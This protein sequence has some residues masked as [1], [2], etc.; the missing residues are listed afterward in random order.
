MVRCPMC[1]AKLSKGGF[2]VV[3]EMKEYV[4]MALRC[5]ACGKLVACA[6]IKARDWAVKT[7]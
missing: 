3:E 2:E 1:D 5:E 7:G 4:E 6:W